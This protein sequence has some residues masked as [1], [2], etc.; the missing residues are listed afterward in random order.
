MSS[1]FLLSSL[2]SRGAVST[3]W[4]S[5]SACAPP[6]CTSRMVLRS[7]AVAPH[8]AQPVQ[9]RRGR[10]EVVCMAHPRR[11]AKVASAIQREIGDMFVSDPVIQAAICPERKLG[12]DALSAVASITDTYVSNDLQVVKVF[13][14]VYSD[15]YGKRVAM[16][17]LQRLEPYV[18]R[19]IGQR[20][21]L[22][23]TPEV[24]FVY[25]DAEEEADLVARV[26]GR[27]EVERYREEIEADMMPGR[28]RG[29]GAN[30]EEEE[31][32]EEAGVEGADAGEG[33]EEDEEEEGE[34]EEDEDFEDP[35]ERPQEYPNPFGDLFIDDREYR[36]VAGKRVEERRRSQG[37][38]QPQGRGQGRRGQGQQREAAAAETGDE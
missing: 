19:L 16:E 35:D 2:C 26:I 14:S 31:A 10:L 21:R 12:D 13:V 15:D 6:A 20:V 32:D 34:F 27:E 9:H 11:V 37:R 25:D 7:R 3:A 8:S 5:S 22:R 23:L 33:E 4:T 29:D 24:R 36:A 1:S 38:P 28:P 30:E 18:R 17:N